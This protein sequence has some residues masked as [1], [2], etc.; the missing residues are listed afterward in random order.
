M[1][2]IILVAVRIKRK[3]EI[4]MLGKKEILV[5][6]AT[7]GL[8]I[9]CIIGSMICNFQMI[10]ALYILGILIFVIRYLLQKSDDDYTK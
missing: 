6:L 2:Y 5:V 9:F 7:Y 10:D 8:I 1:C 4:I 3:R